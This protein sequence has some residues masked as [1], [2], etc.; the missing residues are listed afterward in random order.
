MKDFD[1]GTLVAVLRELLGPW[2]WVSLGVAAVAAVAFLYVVVRDRGVV[3]SRL[4]WS[5]VVAIG[6]VV[7][8]VLITQRVTHSG[9]SDLGGPIDWVLLAALFIAGAI[10]TLIA[11]Y[12]AFGLMSGG[13][14]RRTVHAA[15]PRADGYAP[16]ARQASPRL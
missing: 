13:S 3:P 4:V 7:A 12:A 2:L 6:G 5:E 1:I 15:T 11:A 14:R 8:A 10:G 9:F 16:L